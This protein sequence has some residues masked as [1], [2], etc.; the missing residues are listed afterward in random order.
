M[1]KN[2]YK[3]KYTHTYIHAY[4][5]NIYNYNIC[6][7]L[8]VCVMCVVLISRSNMIQLSTLRALKR[9]RLRS[10]DRTP[11]NSGFGLFCTW[12]HLGYLES[13][14]VRDHTSPPPIKIE[15]L[16]TALFAKWWR[17]KKK[18]A[19]IN[20]KMLVQDLRRHSLVGFNHLSHA[21]PI[22]QKTR[23]AVSTAL[24]PMPNHAKI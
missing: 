10:Y 21:K 9:Q 11:R 20:G 16:W 24:C 14:H 3:N 8:C 2:K 15:L 17:K 12:H 4:N 22:C 6:T 19:E 1:N 23:E 18:R 13:R 7:Y 5:L